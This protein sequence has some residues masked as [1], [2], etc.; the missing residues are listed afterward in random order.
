MKDR[1]IDEILSKAAQGPEGVDPKLLAQVAKSIESTLR[2]VR[3][4]PPAGLMTWGLVFVCA[5]VALAGAAHAGFFGVE[6]LSTLE[7]ALIFPALG[8]FIWFASATWVSQMIPGSKHLVSP[9]TLLGVGSLALICVFAVLFH[10]YHTERFVHSG[11]VCLAVGLLHAIPTG[12]V[13][14]FV[15]RRGF[16]VD[17]VTAGLAAGTLAGLAG[18]VML[19]LHCANLQAFHILLWHTAV[20]PVSGSAGA[21][22]GR[23]IRFWPI[24]TLK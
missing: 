11:L 17:S 16:A 6:K 10:D 9:G 24:L 23:A 21:L 5:A 4:L 12:L 8:I 2:A 1:K 18:V 13:G 7:R 15:L 20:V 14:W 19:E 3:P 22:I